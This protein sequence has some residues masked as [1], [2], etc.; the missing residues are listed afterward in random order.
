MQRTN[1]P[2][3]TK[4]QSVFCQQMKKSM[5]SLVTGTLKRLEMAKKR[6]LPLKNLTIT[7]TI[8]RRRRN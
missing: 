6:K 5:S 7:R 8:K 1:V 2:S 4:G 3:V